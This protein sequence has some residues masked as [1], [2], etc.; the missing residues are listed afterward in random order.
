M[1]PSPPSAASRSRRPSPS[2]CTAATATTRVP[3]CS[4]SGDQKLNSIHEGTT[5]IQSLDL[6]GPQ[7]V[8]AGGGEALRLWSS[9]VTRATAD[10]RSAGVEAAWCDVIDAAVADV[11][12]LT[13]ELGARGSPGDVDG[14]LSTPPLLPTSSRRRASRGGIRQAA[15]DSRR[16]DGDLH[17]PR[18]QARAAQYW[19]A[20]RASASMPHLV[21]A[22]DARE[23]PTCGSRT[24][25]SDVLHA[26]RGGAGLRSR[27]M[28]VDIR[29]HRGLP[30]PTG[31]SSR[32]PARRRARVTGIGERPKEA[33]DASLRH[34][35][36]HRRAGGQRHR[37]RISFEAA[38]RR[39]QRHELNPP[40][41]VVEAHVMAAAAVRERWW[42][43]RHSVHHLLCR[44]KPAR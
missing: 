32:A 28:P 7:V 40:E 12:S 5:G 44:D 21:P 23:T 18:G 8:I 38:V 34:W 14:M 2:R 22:R 37:R 9:E 41:A 27:A 25:G 36:S 39:V 11:A 16:W 13:M 26:P 6:L 42:H 43:P 17:L 35:L 29:A 4:G 20:H 10:A 30:L 33:L 3:A 31:T 24:T 15:A 1:K 19:C